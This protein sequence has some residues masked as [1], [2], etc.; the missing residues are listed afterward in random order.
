MALVARRRGHR[1][2]VDVP[3]DAQHF[4]FPPAVRA[5]HLHAL[6]LQPT[7]RVKQANSTQ[8][9]A[10]QPPKGVVDTPPLRSVVLLLNRRR[11]AAQSDLAGAPLQ[12]VELHGRGLSSTPR[13]KIVSVQRIGLLDV[14]TASICVHRAFRGVR[15]GCRS[16]V[17]ATIAPGVVDA[18]AC[19]SI[20]CPLI[21][22]QCV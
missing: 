10:D 8:L 18:V 22:H 15:C 7:H 17:A 12:R 2:R 5:D 21:V 14:Q 4:S 16:A 6:P 1:S 3:R 20:G 19:P 11:W 13:D 9:T